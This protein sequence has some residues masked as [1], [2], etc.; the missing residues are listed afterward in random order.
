M[1]ER[2]EI[3][4]Q[5]FAVWEFEA[6]LAALEH[7]ERQGFLPNSVSKAWNAFDYRPLRPSG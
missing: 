2:Q 4:P 6:L 7:A 3:G 1:T 5:Y